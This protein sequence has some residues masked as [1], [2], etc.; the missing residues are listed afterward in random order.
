[1]KNSTKTDSLPSISIIK[2]RLGWTFT[3]LEE[4]RM[5]RAIRE[6]N[7]FM[8]TYGKGRKPYMVD[9]SHYNNS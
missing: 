5:R 7:E 8:E 9:K 4:I 1:M 2:Y 3:E 6:A